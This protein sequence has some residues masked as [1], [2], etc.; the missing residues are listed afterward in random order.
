MSNTGWEKDVAYVLATKCVAE[1]DGVVIMTTDVYDRMVEK[2]A[3]WHVMCHAQNTF[4]AHHEGEL[5]DL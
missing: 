5:F 4:P 3:K 2:V 1:R